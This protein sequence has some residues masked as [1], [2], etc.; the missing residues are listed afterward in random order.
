MRHVLFS[1]Q[2]LPGTRH[3]MP[4]KVV[5]AFRLCDAE[6]K[7]RIHPRQKKD[8][9]SISKYLNDTFGQT[10]RKTKQL[11]ESKLKSTIEKCDVHV[12]L[13]SSVTIEAYYLKT[14]TVLVDEEGAEMYKNMFSKNVYYSPNPIKIARLIENV[15]WEKKEEPNEVESEKIIRRRINKLT[16]K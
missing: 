2:P 5:Q 8:L 3:G 4:V 14:P 1:M 9:D 7:F 12:T 6:W 11:A 16:G 10:K 15:E 13:H